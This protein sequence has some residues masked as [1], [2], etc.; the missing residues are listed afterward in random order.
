MITFYSDLCKKKAPK[1]FGA[2]RSIFLKSDNILSTPFGAKIK[3]EKTGV[4]K[5]QHLNFLIFGN[6]NEEISQCQIKK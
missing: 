6:N 1:F 3:K 4:D 5:S 2:F